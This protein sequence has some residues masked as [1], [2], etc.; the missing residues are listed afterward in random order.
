MF[1]FFL[2]DL[3]KETRKFTKI[4]GNKEYQIIHLFKQTYFD[5]FLFNIFLI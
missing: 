4:E 1:Q 5:F 2:L 3:G